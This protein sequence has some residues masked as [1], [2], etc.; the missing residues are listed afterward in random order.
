MS[1]SEK[2]S[3]LFATNDAENIKLARNIVIAQAK[4]ENVIALICALK[5]WKQFDM[6]KERDVIDA[7]NK[8][9]STKVGEKEM[10][11]ESVNYTMPTLLRWALQQFK[12]IENIDYAHHVYL[13]HIQTLVNKAH[14]E[15][16]VD[17]VVNKVLTEDS[18]VGDD[19]ELPF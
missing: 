13:I 10:S 14:E 12:S 9:L 8:V 18:G 2:V 16:K 11:W 15:I 6:C 17:K 7:I 3:K 19:D 1:L 4:Q 5:K